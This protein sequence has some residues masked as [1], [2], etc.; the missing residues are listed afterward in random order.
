MDTHALLPLLDVQSN[1]TGCCPLTLEEMIDPVLLSD[2]R[3]YE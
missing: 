2:G 1:A 3:V